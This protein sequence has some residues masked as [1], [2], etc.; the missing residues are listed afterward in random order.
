MEHKQ[1]EEI[2]REFDDNVMTYI[3]KR[4]FVEINKTPAFVNGVI[5]ENGSIT[6]KSKGWDYTNL[7][8]FVMALKQR[9]GEENLRELLDVYSG[10]SAVDDLMIMKSNKKPIDNKRIAALK[11]IVS[12]VESLG[13]LENVREQGDYIGESDMP[14]DAKISW[15]LTVL[16]FLIYSLK[17]DRLVTSIEFDS[18]VITSVEITFYVRGCREYSDIKSFVD[19]SGLSTDG[20]INGKA[21]RAI[22]SCATDMM[23][24]CLLTNDNSRIEDQSR[25][26]EKLSAR[27]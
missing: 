3:A 20:K 19:S 2:K 22:V 12:K 15:A 11:R 6:G 7:D 8:R 13:Y 9:I 17:A 27:G 25:N 4:V 5:D 26:W 16:T 24:G 10:Y 14:M 23:E 1:Y 21:I 18:N